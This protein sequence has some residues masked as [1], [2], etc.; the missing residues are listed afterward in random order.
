[1]ETEDAA[2]ASGAAGEFHH[3]ELPMLFPTGAP[4][5]GLCSLFSLP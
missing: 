4:E 3:E 2:G 5:A 1:M